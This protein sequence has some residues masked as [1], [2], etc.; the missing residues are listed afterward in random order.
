MRAP[1]LF[2]IAILASATAWAQ[3]SSEPASAATSAAPAP[4]AAQ[5]EQ[6]NSA[7]PS[8]QNQRIERIRE[9]DAGSRVD[10]LRV[11]GQTQSINVQPKAG[12]MPSYEVKP[13]NA[14]KDG[15]N[16]SG[17]DGTN[18]RRVWNLKF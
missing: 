16:Q 14:G 17:S 3:P 8:R 13:G 9:E 12:N 15:I 2:S 5:P 1:I 4:A 11:G 10:E 18:G 6:G 7:A